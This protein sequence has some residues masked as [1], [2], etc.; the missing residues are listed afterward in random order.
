MGP[1][2]APV[3][4]LKNEFRYQILLKAA[5]DP[6]CAKSLHASYGARGKGKWNEQPPW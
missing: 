2:E 5:S 1:A 6:R 3:A 4:R